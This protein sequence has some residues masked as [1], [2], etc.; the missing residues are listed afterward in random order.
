[1]MYKIYKVIEFTIRY[2][3]LRIRYYF[4][5]KKHTEKIIRFDNELY[6]FEKEIN[7]TFKR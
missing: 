3:V 2:Y 6:E 1:M 7:E 4:I 5:N